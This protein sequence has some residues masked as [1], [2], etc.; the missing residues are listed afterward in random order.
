M[1]KLRCYDY[2][3]RDYQTVSAA[4]LPDPRDVLVRATSSGERPELHL[5]VGDNMIRREIELLIE[6]IVE[7]RD[8]YDHPTLRIAMTW[9]AA[10]HPAMYPTMRATLSIYPLSSTETQLD[11]EGTYDPPLGV[12]GEALDAIAF[13]RFAEASVGELVRELAIYL[14]RDVAAA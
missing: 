10:Q 14:R 2:V 9:Q 8:D 3:N 11:L 4:L 7:T 12:V 6:S 5:G 1:K 13:H